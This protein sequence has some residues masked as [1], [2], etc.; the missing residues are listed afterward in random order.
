MRQRPKHGE[1][2]PGYETCNIPEGVSISDRPL[3][4][5]LTK[6]PVDV[7][8]FYIDFRSAEIYLA[9]DRNQGEVEIAAAVF[10]FSSN[11]TNV[12]I[13]NIIVE[14]YSNSAQT[15]AIN[16]RSAAS[17]SIEN[18]E[19]RWNSGAGIS[20]GSG[21]HVR[22]SDVHHNGQ[23]GIVG[24]DEKLDIDNNVI[25][26][27][28]TR[29]FNFKW[30]AGGVKSGLSDG[31]AVSR[32]GIDDRSWFWGADILI[33]A[34]QEVQVYRNV[35]SVSP[36]GCGIVLIDQGRVR[37]NGEKYKTRN[38]VVHDNEMRFEGEACVGAA[39]DV[40]PDHENYATIGDGNNRFD[41]NVYRVPKSRRSG[42][43]FVFGHSVFDWSGWRNRGLEANGLL[44]GY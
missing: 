24:N 31:G 18:V 36:E 20:M 5:V 35:V 27:N 1:C 43:R 37:G 44:I 4:P 8:R 12:L 38:N 29:G 22:W 2:A 40:A 3:V 16:G 34:S 14:K 13:R 17:W 23:I 10:A 33:A 9:D 11:A 21:G 30:E 15:G 28:N 32:N 41:G 39:S 19:A 7:G 25:W 6:E 26:A 42:H